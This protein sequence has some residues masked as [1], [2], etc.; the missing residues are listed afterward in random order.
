MHT[1][2]DEHS[3]HREADELVRPHPSS[4]QMFDEW[5]DAHSL[6]AASVSWSNAQD[7]ATLSIPVSVAESMLGCTFHVYKHLESGEQAIRTLEYALPR[8]LLE[9]VDTI[10]PTTY[11]GFG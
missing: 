10:Q 4:L 3:L 2:T 9:H 5:L 8:R 7:W 1:Y 6:D 11:F